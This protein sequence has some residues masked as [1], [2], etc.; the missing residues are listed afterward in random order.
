MFNDVEEVD[1]MHQLLGSELTASHLR[2]DGSA[3]TACKEVQLCEGGM[4][5]KKV[6]IPHIQSIATLTNQRYPNRPTAH[7]A[8][9]FWDHT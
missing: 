8:N 6:K 5:E 2:G 9:G 1:V 3:P 7:S 4:L